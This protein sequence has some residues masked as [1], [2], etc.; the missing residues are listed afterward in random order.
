MLTR[1]LLVFFSFLFISI[2]VAQKT[3]STGVEWE[4][5]K[6]HKI[7][8]T[9]KHSVGK[10]VLFSAVLPGLG[11]AYNKKWWKIPIV[12]VAI[13]TP[14]YFL[15]DYQ[16][17][18]KFYKT[19]IQKRIDDPNY[20]FFDPSYDSLSILQLQRDYQS[21]RDLCIFL[22]A[23]FY[24]LNIIDAAVDAQLFNYDVSR[25]LSMRWS[26]TF[27]NGAV[28]VGLQFRFKT[29]KPQLNFSLDDSF[30]DEPSPPMK[31]P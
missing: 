20:E 22:T 12:Y 15:I 18:Q 28:G 16:T 1:L 29:R 8:T 4:K 30:L 7:D 24:L 14:M 27:N 2:G 9:K 21:K 23:G 25:D 10:A 13:G 3:D 26:P 11:Q 6:K 31:S 17:K 5:E 19:E